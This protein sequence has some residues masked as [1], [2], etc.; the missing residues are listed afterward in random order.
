[1]KRISIILLGLVIVFALIYLSKWYMYISALDGQSNKWYK[2]E[3][4]EKEFKGKIKYIQMFDEN[5]YKIIISID[6]GSEFEISYGVTCVDDEFNNFVTIGDSVM[7]EKG[8]KVIKFIKTDRR[9]KVFELNFCD[10][11]K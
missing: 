9:N 11:F 5:P 7:K 1:M 8:T 3:Y 6:D 2:E 4:V 10:K